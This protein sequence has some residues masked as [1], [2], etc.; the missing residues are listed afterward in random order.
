MPQFPLPKEVSELRTFKTWL[1]SSGNTYINTGNQVPNDIEFGL[2]DGFGDAR[3]ANQKFLRI[4]GDK[5]NTDVDVC[6]MTDIGDRPGPDF[7]MEIVI[8]ANH[9]DAFADADGN[10][11]NN[12]QNIPARM[13]FDPFYLPLFSDGLAVQDFSWNHV[14]GKGSDHYYLG[15]ME[16]SDIPGLDRPAGNKTDQERITESLRIFFT[17]VKNLPPEDP[18]LVALVW[19]N[20]GDVRYLVRRVQAGQPPTIT[21]TTPA[22]NAP[23]SGYF[24]FL[25]DPLDA[26][27]FDNLFS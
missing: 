10:P 24:K 27:A 14:T 2:I 4:R 1:T 16:M 18:V 26:E 22:P 17:A 23:P 11:L 15:L 21:F 20:S 3:A 25:P 7:L 19:S 5:T 8:D 13:A 9:A 6:T 12:G